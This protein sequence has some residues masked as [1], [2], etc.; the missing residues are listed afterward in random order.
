MKNVS[1]I[2]QTCTG[3]VQNRMIKKWGAAGHVEHPI[4]LK[5]KTG[6]F[7]VPKHSSADEPRNARV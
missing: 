7:V 1:V 4:L 3:R 5:T 6:C 2:N